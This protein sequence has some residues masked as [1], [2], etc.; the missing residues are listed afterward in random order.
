[1][2]LSLTQQSAAQTVALPIRCDDE[3]VQL[4]D[5]TFDVDTDRCD[6]ARALPQTQRKH[7]RVG[8][9]RNQLVQRLHQGWHGEVMVGL[10]FGDI[11][12]A[13]KCEHLPTVR[14][15]QSNQLDRRPNDGRLHAVRVV[16]LV[17]PAMTTMGTS[18]G[19][20]TWRNTRRPA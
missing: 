13:L 17:A 9:L 3:T 5:L 18:L 2:F 20:D 19:Q 14:R 16:M 11:R 6:K 1:V 15:G 12:R 7:L 4:G 8:Q 10:S